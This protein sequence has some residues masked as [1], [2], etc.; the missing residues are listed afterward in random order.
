VTARALARVSAAALVLRLASVAPAAAP[1][2]QLK[3]VEK[4]IEDTAKEAKSIE[5]KTEGALGEVDRLDRSISE[6][7]QRVTGLAADI[8]AAKHRRDAAERR[9]A[10]LDAELPRLRERFAERARGLYRLTR[11]GLGPVVFAAPRQWSETLRY[12]RSLQAVMAHDRAIVVE[13]RQNRNDAEAARAEAAANAAKLAAS[14]KENERELATLREE[15]EDKQK[16]VASLRG[17]GAE[18]ARALDEL[19]ASAEK[20]R[21]LIE[22]DEKAS[23]AAPFQPPPG[24]AKL[25]M[26]SPLPA[27]AKQVV[28]AR[29]GVEIRIGS[30]TPIHAVKAGRVVFAG[31]FAGYG[32]M[33]ILDHGDHLYSI[34][35]YAG[36]ITVEQGQEVNGGD[37]IASVG[38]T[39]PVATPSLYFEIRDHGTARDPGVYI[40]TL[41]RK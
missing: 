34:Y 1:G 26:M 35:G 7:E 25:R 6:R 13:M 41:A 11:G 32:K 12:R 30:G 19:K 17:E 23:K 9:I 24:T 16:L 22:R 3:E 40:P 5:E 28:T 20:L 8:R 39:G 4:K 10:K 36:E 15:R 27:A 37:A 18:R 31:W 29:N 14:R 2:E 38:S 33:V 21:D